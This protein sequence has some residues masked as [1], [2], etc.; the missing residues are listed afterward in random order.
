[1]SGRLQTLRVS[2]NVREVQGGERMQKQVPFREAIIRKYPEPVAVALAKTPSGVVNPITLGWVMPSSHTP[3]QF[4]ISVGLTRYS[5]EVIR[6]AGEFVL[7]FP[8]VEQAEE[9]LFFGT[10]S[11]RSFD[12][13][14]ARNVP[15]Q[16]T[17]VID[18]LLLSEAVA[19]F[20]C[21]LVGEL[22]SGDHVIFVG[23]VVA[24]HVNVEPKKRLY[25]IGPDHLLG[26]AG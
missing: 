19:N 13:L 25:T 6:E 15:T 17:A 7:S 9:A 22:L 4:A 26:P 23:E 18:S 2:G 8:S 24:S 14:A 3:P 20:E 16:P 10:E 1:M 11:G 21:V 5:L 12:K